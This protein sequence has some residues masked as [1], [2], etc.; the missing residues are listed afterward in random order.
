MNNLNDISLYRYVSE[1]EFENQEAFLRKDLMSMRVSKFTYNGRLHSEY[2]QS[3]S[4]NSMKKL[5]S[6]DVPCQ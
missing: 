3:I 1:K 2:C 4:G 6:M 5:L